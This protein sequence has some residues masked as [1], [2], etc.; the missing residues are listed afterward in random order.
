MTKIEFVTLCEE[1][2]IDSS[3]ALENQNVYEG[4]LNKD[5]ERVLRAMREEF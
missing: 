1:Y 5:R 2:T 3:I 4:L